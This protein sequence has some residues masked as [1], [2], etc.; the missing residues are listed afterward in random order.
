M[1]SLNLPLVLLW[2]SCSSYAPIIHPHLPCVQLSRHLPFIPLSSFVY[3]ISMHWSFLP[4]SAIASSSPSGTCHSFHHLPLYQSVLHAPV[5]SLLLCHSV[6]LSSTSSHSFSTHHCI[7]HSS[8][9]LLLQVCLPSPLVIHSPLHDLPWSP[10]SICILLFGW[11]DFA[12]LLPCTGRG[13]SCAGVK[14]P[15]VSIHRAPKELC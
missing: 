6:T 12:S 3:K 11:L 5:H 13:W 2:P 10:I 9:H 15:V 8:T 14:P 7:T 1:A 4:L